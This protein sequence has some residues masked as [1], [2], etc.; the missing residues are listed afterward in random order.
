MPLDILSPILN[1]PLTDDRYRLEDGARM[2]GYQLRATQKVFTGELVRDEVTGLKVGPERDGVAVHIDP[3]LGKTIIGLTAIVEW[4]KWAII[5]KPVLLIAPIKVCE[6]VWRQEARGWSHTRHLTFQLI[7]GTEKERAFA[8]ARPAHVYLVN[9]ELLVWLQTYIRTDWGKYFDAMIIDESSMFKDHKAKRFRVLSNYGTKVALKGPDGKPLKDPKTGQTIIT[10]PHKFK[11][12][13]VL[14]GTPSPSGLQNLWAPIY[15]MDQGKRLHKKFET[16]HGRFFHKTQQVAAHVYK[17]A[18]NNEEDE[19]RPLWQVMQGGPERIHELIADIT[20]ELNAEDYGVLPKQLP[21]FKHYVELPDA[22]KPHYRQLEREAVFEMLADPILAA[23]GGAK[24]NMCW[25]ICNGAMYNTD[26]NGQ[27]TW[28]ELHTAKLDKL[29]ELIDELDQHCLIPY[30]FNHDL[31]RIV[32]RFKKEGI[33]YAV[34]KGRNTESIINRWNAKQIPNLL[35]HP[36]SA[37]HGLNLQFGGHNLIW[38]STVW[39]LE[40]WLQT[41]AR[42]AR[43]GQ[44]EV[45]AIH[46][47]MARNTTDE[48]R[49]QSVLEHGSDMERFRKALLKYQQ[50]I[51][52]DL[53][54]MPMLSSGAFEG[55]KL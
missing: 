9:P 43:S 45:V 27:R 7:R 33:P 38:F 31:E 44:K 11:R 10:P 22:I 37:A 19:I 1:A 32:A 55:I 28:A 23:N 12:A 53:G 21:P 36:Q 25:Q 51:G 40:R 3:G 46:V 15:L 24:S 5:S 48:V 6:T 50:Q 47:I 54:S 29:V 17:H 52:L 8:L 49:Y 30:H 13:A 39:S 14:T 26:I 20:I 34:L 2:R 16:F 42:L 18:L 41:V 4:F 35:I